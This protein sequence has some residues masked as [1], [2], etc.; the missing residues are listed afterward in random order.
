MVELQGSCCSRG[1]LWMQ[2]T[3][4]A[5]GSCT[6][7]GFRTPS[8]PAAWDE[9]LTPSQGGYR[10]QCCCGCHQR[11]GKDALP[12]TGHPG[13]RGDPSC[14]P[15][16]ALAQA[17]VQPAGLTPTQSPS[18]LHSLTA[19]PGPACLASPLLGTCL[20]PM[21]AGGSRGHELML[22][23]EGKAPCGAPSLPHVRQLT[24][25]CGGHRSVAVDSRACRE[26][27]AAWPCQSIASLRHRA[28]PP[29]ARAP[30]VPPTRLAKAWV[31]K[32]QLGAGQ[33]GAQHAAGSW[34]FVVVK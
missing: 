14:V 33:R 1:G 31:S 29:C 16:A 27:C 10:G 19:R 11:R 25:A 13:Q 20:T 32:G 15:G 2:D 26:P 3:G 34:C 17:S 12:H 6:G 9:P 22:S 18:A 4:V 21:A 5:T 7:M 8:P 24:Q 28:P 30:A 23:L